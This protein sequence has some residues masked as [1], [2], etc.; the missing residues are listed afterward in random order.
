[1]NHEQFKIMNMKEE[2]ILEKAIRKFKDITGAKMD[3]IDNVLTK[4][5]VNANAIIKLTADN[6]EV[7]FWVEV[8]NEIREQNL[9]KF[10]YFI[11]NNPTEWLLVCQYIPKPLKEN[12]KNKGIN[13]LETAGNCFI[14]KDGLFFY[15]ND[16][17]VTAE[18]QPLE[19]KLWK[20]AG[21]KFVFGILT[22]P[23]L[24]NQPHRQMA[25][26]TN[27]ALG[28]IGQLIGELKQE[29]FL[30][31]GN[32]EGK[33]VHFIENKEVLQNKWIELFNATLKPKLKQ[34]RFRFINKE[35]ER[36]WKMLP[37]AIPYK[38]YWGGEP[39]AAIL[40]DYLQPEIFTI[41]TREAKGNIMKQLHLVPDKAGNVE[42]LDAFWNTPLLD[43]IKLEAKTAPP[44]LVY[45]ELITSL[46]SRNRETAERIKQKYLG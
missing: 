23:E 42:I 22:K 37:Y 14:R 2:E 33:P 19:G 11:K 30:K 7:T 20:Q 46:D 25:K 13:Y 38:F 4:T 24:L 8:K 18:R 32:R 40:T 6:Q 44:F 5:H 15:I 21:L 41:Y 17:Q 34:G 45:A 27:I 29:G 12:L 9:P 43:F 35:D 36:N 31:E 1:M 39:A 16:K 26:E 28:N 10:L 3:V